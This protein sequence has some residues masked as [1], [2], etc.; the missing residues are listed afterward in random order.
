L[1]ISVFIA[2][3]IALTGKKHFPVLSSGLGCCCYR[4]KRQYDRGHDFV[5]GFQEVISIKVFSL[6]AYPCAADLENKVSIA[7][8][9]ALSVMIR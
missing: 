6:W 7:E 9:T 1:N 8:D 4:D 5:N 3:R 2:K